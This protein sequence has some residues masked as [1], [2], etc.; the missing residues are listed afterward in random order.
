MTPYERVMTALDHCNPDRPP[1]NYIATPELNEKLKA[2][3]GIADQEALLQFLGVDIR[4]VAG[5]YVGPPH[6]SGA[7]GVTAQGTDFLGI[8]WK[9]ISYGLGSYNEIAFSILAHVKTVKEV[10]EYP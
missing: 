5:R 4:Y 6:L 10:E 7:A 9:P 2:H 8:K 3:L 1:I